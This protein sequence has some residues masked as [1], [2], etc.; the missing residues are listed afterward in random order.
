MELEAL[1]RAAY[2]RS[3]RLSRPLGAGFRPNVVGD[4]VGEAP[5][6]AGRRGYHFSPICDQ[7]MA[8]GY[9][10]RTHQKNRLFP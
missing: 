10:A 2:Q 6:V 7:G 9:F 1:D 5:L 3:L 8:V 4:Q